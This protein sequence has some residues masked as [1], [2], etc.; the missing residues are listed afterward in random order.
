MMPIVP[1]FFGPNMKDFTGPPSDFCNLRS[2]SSRSN[3]SARLQSNLLTFFLEERLTRSKSESGCEL[4]IVTNLG[5]QIERQVCAVERDVVFEGEFQL[6]A[7][8]SS[9]WLQTWPK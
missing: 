2:S 6:P 5:M 9:Y 4:R 8:H 1:V 3:E 7:Q